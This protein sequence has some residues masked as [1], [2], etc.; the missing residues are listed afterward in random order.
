MCKSLGLGTS[1]FVSTKDKWDVSAGL[2][3]NAQF[4]QRFQDVWLYVSGSDKAKYEGPRNL[5]SIVKLAL[6]SFIAEA[7]CNAYCDRVRSSR[8]AQ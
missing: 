8:P 5:Y 1:G 2:T 7:S 6:P 4:T 3:V